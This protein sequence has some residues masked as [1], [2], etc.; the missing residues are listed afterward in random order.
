MGGPNLA[1][2]ALLNLNWILWRFRRRSQVRNLCDS[3]LRLASS[4]FSGAL[5]FGNIPLCPF[6]WGGFGA[7]SADFVL[8]IR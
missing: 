8:I 2:S 4:D 1:V 3:L 6:F 5:P 7:G